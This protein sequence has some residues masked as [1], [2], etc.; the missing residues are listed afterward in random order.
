MYLQICFG[1]RSVDQR[2]KKKKKGKKGTFAEPLYLALQNGEMVFLN[3]NNQLYVCFWSGKTAMPSGFR[4]AHVGCS[5]VTLSTY[6]SKPIFIFIESFR[7]DK[8]SATSEIIP[9][10]SNSFFL[11]SFVFSQTTL[12]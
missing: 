7:K 11:S 2:K 6:K 8:I 10:L 9:C 1:E 4:S 3:L 12:P 5:C